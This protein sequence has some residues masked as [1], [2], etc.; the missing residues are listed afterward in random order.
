MKKDRG[1]W[2]DRERER[3]RERCPRFGNIYATL[4]DSGSG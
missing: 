1:K 2:R 4:L 3:E